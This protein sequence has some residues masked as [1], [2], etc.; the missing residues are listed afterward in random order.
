MTKKSII[1]TAFLWSMLFTSIVGSAEYPAGYYDDLDGKNKSAL[2]NAAGKAVASHKEISYGNSTWEAFASTDVLVIDGK[3]YWWDRYSPNLVAAPSSHNGLNIEHSVPKSWWGGSSNSAYKD[4]NHL[5]PSDQNANSRKGNYPLAPVG[6]QSWTNGVTI[7]GKPAAG[8]G[9]GATI[10]YEPVDEYKGDFARIY[11]YMFSMYPSISWKSGTD[12]MYTVGE[13]YPQFRQWAIDML[14][15]WNRMDPVDERERAR[16]EAVFIEQKNRNPFIDFPDLAEYIW[17]NKMNETFRVD[18]GHNP[19]VNPEI[20]S[21]VAGQVLDFGTHRTGTAATIPLLVKGTS[22]KT[23]LSLTLQGADCFTVSATEVTVDEAKGGKE[24]TVTYRPVSEG[25]FSAVLTVSGGGAEQSVPVTIMGAARENSSLQPTVALDPENIT[26]T[27]YRARWNPAMTA[28][29]YYVVTRTYRRNGETTTRRYMTSD[30]YYDFR[31]R[32][33]GADDSYSV[34]YSSAGELSDPSNTVTLAAGSLSVSTVTME[35]IGI[36][37]EKGGLYFSSDY[38]GAPIIV[39][40]IT[41]R[42]VASFGSITMGTY[43]P[44][45]TG[46]YLIRTNAPARVF[47]VLIK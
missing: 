15:E 42:T 17:G 16:N 31:D 1:S 21:P 41:G 38:Y 28:A 32:D 27:S 47:K 6:Q 4:I 23:P 45:P 13:T 44:L 2:K 25:S 36:L 18:G 43:L 14:L 29:D 34:Q 8:Y 46:I 7:I 37:V 30:T 26:T 9:G 20:V 19:G 35:S 24:I 11:F 40:D 39:C 3:K 22:L 33:F 12:W 5:N 10:V